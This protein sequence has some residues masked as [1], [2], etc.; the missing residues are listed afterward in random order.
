MDKFEPKGQTLGHLD[1]ED[2]NVK[3]EK[4]KDSARKFL[5]HFI[6]NFIHF[7]YTDLVVFLIMKVKSGVALVIKRAVYNLMR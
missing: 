2:E 4:K 6:K 3:L 7:I 5:E 1:Y